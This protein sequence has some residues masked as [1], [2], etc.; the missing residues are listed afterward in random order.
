MR[1]EPV[2]FSGRARKEAG[3]HANAPEASSDSKTRRISLSCWPRQMKKE[4]TVVLQK[5]ILKKKFDCLGIKKKKNL[6]THSK[7]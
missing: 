2:D 3:D 4:I 1:A 5:C 7:P 6:G